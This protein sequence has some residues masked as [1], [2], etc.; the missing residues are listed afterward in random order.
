MLKQFEEISIFTQF[1]AGTSTGTRSQKGLS[2]SLF[3]S[4]VEESQHFCCGGAISSSSFMQL[5]WIG[6]KLEYETVFET[7]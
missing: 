3:M 5:Y 4:A 2:R 6:F 1:F 7:F